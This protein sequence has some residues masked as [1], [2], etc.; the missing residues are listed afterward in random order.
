MKSE[1]RLERFHSHSLN[2]IL[3]LSGVGLILISCIIILITP[4]AANYEFSLYDVYP[5]YFW[6][7]LIASIVTGSSILLINGLGNEQE[8]NHWIL[9]ILI[10][11]LADSILLFMPFI[12]GYLNFGS[13][14]VLTHIGWMKDII[15]KGYVGHSNMYPIDHILG[16]ILHFFTGLSLQQITMIIPALFSLFFIISFYLLST[17]IF[18]KQ[19]ECLFLLL[20]AS[21]LMFG[22]S[23]MAFAPNAQAFMLLPFLL[24]L[25]FKSN[26]SDEKRI[27]SFLLILIC[28]LL[29]YFH[30]L[31]T[32]I[33]ISILLLLKILSWI[34]K[35]KDIKDTYGKNLNKLI[36]LLIILFFSWSS[37]L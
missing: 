2:R 36:F 23:Q 26:I 13:G 29:V 12:R 14:D 8:N 15:H 19:S 27:F 5:F 31:I 6:L 17:L 21:I 3:A 28:T 37:Y 35:K 16:V 34:L 24:Y 18:S 30:P 25:L 20:F 4:S 33:M 7:A 1:T 9:G 10:I 11:F 32:V 22:N